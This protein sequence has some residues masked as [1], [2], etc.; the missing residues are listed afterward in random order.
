MTSAGW[1]KIVAARELL[2]LGD[3]ATLAEIKQ[4]YRRLARKHHPD[5]A[6]SR[7]E[8]AGGQSR[9]MQRLAEAY[10]VLMEYCR[11][12]RF[13]LA[14]EEGQLLEGE[15]WWLERFG[16]DPFWGPGRRER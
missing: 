12:F 4:A 1:G 8:T 11:Q 15:D 9:E 3:Q 7:G 10:Q 5:L 2:G 13:P 16:D 6:R 14:P